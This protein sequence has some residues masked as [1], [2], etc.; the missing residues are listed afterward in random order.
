LDIDLEIKNLIE[1]ISSEYNVMP[2]VYNS[3]RKFVPHK[4]PIYYSGPIWDED[5]VVA[6][7]RT[8]LIGK[9]LASGENV[10]KFEFEFAKKVNN[11]FGVMVNSGSSANLVM[12]AALK[13]FFEW[14]DGSEIIVSVVGFPTTIS[15]VPQNGLVPVFV[16]IEM[17]TLNFNLDKIEEKITSKTKAI[18]VS[19]VLGNPPD[20]DKILFL[21]EKH[22]LKLILD[23]CDSL[24]SKWR[25]KYLNEY[26]VA[27]SNSFYAAHHI[28]TIHGGMVISDNRNIINYARNYSTWA[29]GCVCSGTEN[30]LPD[31]ICK[32][33]FD[34]WIE[35]YD[36]VVDHKYVFTGMGYNLQPLDLQG[37]IGLEQLNKI[38]SIHENR[39]KSKKVLSNL[40]LKY[41]TNVHIPSEIG[42]AETSWFG[43][44][45]VCNNS[46]QK[47]K[48]LSYLET[49]L[50]QTR[51]YFA[52]NI[53][54]HK[55]FAHLGDFREY[56]EANKVLDH[57]FFIG[58]S[59]LYDD[60][61]FNYVEDV[62]KGYE[63]VR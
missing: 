2:Y 22:G 31:G 35:N 16:D 11:L 36:G 13:K 47:H 61:I 21:C 57:V 24:G 62:L 48:L 7:I 15:V 34:K 6:A 33:R 52:G 58:A 9:W 14:Q 37:A 46:E 55:G 30:L 59:P 63:N 54:M 10:Q 53:L 29:R 41:V 5:E 60:D 27:S 51:H 28:S 1:K 50:I 23:N 3:R 18:F 26:A 44:P 42:G 49:N 38:D 19:P 39:K 45:I 25:G 17:D 12:I 40:I 43:T 32:H 56:P 20:F 4:T 8:L